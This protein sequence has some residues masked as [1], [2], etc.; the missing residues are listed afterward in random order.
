MSEINIAVIGCTA[1]LLLAFVPLMS[2]PEGAGDFIRSLPIAVVCTI[3]S[4]L[5]VSLTIVPF[6]ASRALPKLG[7]GHSNVFLDVVMGGIHRIYRPAL[8]VALGMAASDDRRG[9]RDCLR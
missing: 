5:L 2:L 7:G 4:S 8:H 9:A 3:A 6:L 1:T